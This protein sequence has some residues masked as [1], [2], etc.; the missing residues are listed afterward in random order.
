MLK[1]SLALFLFFILNLTVLMSQNNGQSAKNVLGEALT[2]CCTDPLTGFYRNGLCDTDPEDYGTHVV[3]ALMTKEFLEFT[4][5][6]GNDLSTPRP[7][8]NFPG[9]EPGDKW[10]L[11]ALRWKEAYEHEAAPKVILK[12]THEKALQYI[13]LNILKEYALKKD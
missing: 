1:Y 4:K 13:D 12:S 8:Y 6:R 9:L 10:C 2:T 7:E 5:T 11:C 3:C